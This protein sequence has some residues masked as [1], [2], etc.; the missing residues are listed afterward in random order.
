MYTLG[1]CINFLKL[2][3][4]E[5]EILQ[6]LVGAKIHVLP[7]RTEARIKDIVYNQNMENFNGF[8][9]I[10]FWK[11]RYNIDIDKSQAIASVSFGPS[12]KPLNYPADT[13]YLDK[14]EIE[15]RIGYWK[16]KEA[17]ALEPR[18]RVEKTRE[19]LTTCFPE[20]KMKISNIFEL[21]IMRK[22][23]SWGELTSYGFCCKMTRVLPPNLIFSKDMRNS[24]HDPRAIFKFGPYAS[25]KDVN[26]WKMFIPVDYPEGKVQSFIDLVGS[27]YNQHQFGRLLSETDKVIQR[28]PIQLY[29]PKP[30]GEVLRKI[31]RNLPKPDGSKTNIALVVIPDEFSP[32]HDLAKVIINEELNMPDQLIREQT[33]WQISDKGNYSLAKTLAL[34]LFIKSLKNMGEVPWILSRPSDGKGKTVYV[35]FGFSREPLTGREAN[36]FFAVCDSLGKLVVQRTVGIPFKSRYID[37]AWITDFF[38]EIRTEME[39]IFITNFERIVVYRHGTMYDEEKNA[40]FE[41]LD[42]KKNDDYW[43][44]V[45]VDFISV[46]PTFKR[47]FKSGENYS[48]PE[49]GICVILNE[50]EALFSTS[51]IH[52]R[53]LTQ[54]TVIPVHIVKETKTATKIQDIV[55]EYH[56]RSY[57]NWMAPVT[58]SK[59]PLELH[60]ANN[61]AEIARFTRREFSYIYV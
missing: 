36:S 49:A 19:V 31:I 17:L 2:T 26:I 53:T 29:E 16:E 7:K 24:S 55:K 61:L 59:W 37:I 21:K 15:K 32:L 14:R 13:I 11:S 18:R 4:G 38:R 60:I 40:L 54:G 42:S 58:G 22:M 8:D 57:L 47:I 25:K 44:G 10:Q 1:D 43:S 27:A 56:D 30:N 20:D 35:G 50:N 34:Q 9:Y 28:I 3:Y 12:L 23:P 5:K 45:N 39:K 51:S 6:S 48:N 46:K 41:W 52:E 33:F